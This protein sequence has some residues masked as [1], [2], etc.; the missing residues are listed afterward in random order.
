M[1]PRLGDIITERTADKTTRGIRPLGCK[2]IWPYNPRAML[3]VKFQAGK[4]SSS[5]EPTPTGVYNKLNIVGT[6]KK[7]WGHK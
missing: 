3:A 1:F 7:R 5:M 4:N 2:Q 6:A